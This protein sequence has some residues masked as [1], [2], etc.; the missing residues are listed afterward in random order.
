VS[1]VGL[2]C[3]NFG[4]GRAL[5]LEAA[6]AVV[7]AAIEGGITLFDTAASYG[8]GTSESILGRALGNHRGDVVLATKIGGPRARREGVALGSRRYIRHAVDQCLTRL[9]TDYIDLLQL[10][11]PDLVTPPDETLSALDDLVREGKVLYAGSSNYAAWMLAEAEL[12]ARHSTQST[13]LVSAQYIYNLVEREIEPDVIDVCRRYDIALLAARPLFN[14]VLAKAESGGGVE[15]QVSARNEAVLKTIAAFA[16]ELG[17]SRAEVA[18]GLTASLP[19]VTSVLCSASHPDQVRANARSLEWT[20]DGAL[21]DVL[22]S[23]D[24]I[25]GNPTP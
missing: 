21:A 20:Q 14:G 24:A 4:T 17:V 15:A 7:A 1:A 2:G 6:S 8:D 23:L 13:R 12:T 18:L 16:A 19:A 10:H 25:N 11:V 22:A 9:G 3:R 5:D